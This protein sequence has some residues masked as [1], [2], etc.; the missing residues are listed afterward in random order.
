MAWTAEKIADLFKIK[1]GKGEGVSSE[2]AE[3]LRTNGYIRRATKSEFITRR[4]DPEPH[5]C[6]ILQGKVRL[7]AFTVDGGEILT[8]FLGHGET[9]GVH[10]CMGG[11]CETMD[12]VV[13]S[14]TA[15]TLMLRG[16]VL[17]KLAWERCD[18]MEA[19][20]G[21]LCSRLNMATQ[22]LEQHGTW[23]ARERLAWRILSLANASSGQPLTQDRRELA[24]SQESLAGLVRL[25]WQ[26]T[27][28]LLKLFEAEGAISLKYGKITLESAEMLKQELRST[29]SLSI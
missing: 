18:L 19:M 23:T 21:I 25:S 28:K 22:F 12:G 8:T 29:R 14:R 4:G 7:T 10:P 26:R 27:N 24:I 3:A 17:K 2:T 16:Q 1:E 20:L 13:E 6:L 11:Y 15:E 5:F 9:W